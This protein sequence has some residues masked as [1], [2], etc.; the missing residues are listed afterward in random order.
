MLEK[1]GKGVLAPVR[2]GKSK[3][4]G[5]SAEGERGGRVLTARGERGD[6]DFV[7]KEEGREKG[8]QHASMEPFRFHGN[9]EKKDSCTISL[10][11]KKEKES[12]TERGIS[13]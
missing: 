10:R 4:S 9:E 1:K 6:W 8:V 13:L 2:K 12:L 7:G 11:K 5:A 3:S